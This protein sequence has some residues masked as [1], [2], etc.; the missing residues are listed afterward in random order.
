SALTDEDGEF[1]ILDIP[2]GRYSVAVTFIGYDMITKSNV[3]VLLDLTT[4]L[5]FSIKIRTAEI[6]EPII[7]TAERPLV[8][9]D[10]TASRYTL[11][12]DQIAYLPN[13][14][15]IADVLTNMS[16]AVIGRNGKL[17]IRG[18]RAGH[19]T[20]IFN[21]VNVTDP[22]NRNVGLRI[23]PSTLEEI[24]LTSG[25][26]PAEY[27]EAG[28]GVVNAV[29]REGG[30]SYTGS[31]KIYDGSTQKFDVNTGDFE[32]LARSDNQAVI[33]SISGP[34]EF[35]GQ[36]KA[37]FFVAA[38]GLRDGGY[39]PHNF[40]KSKTLTGKLTARP[41]ANIKI[42]V[43]G[44]IFR[45]A[46]DKFDH[47]DVNGISYNFNLDGSGLIKKE[48]DVLGLRSTLS[49]NPTTIIN[50]G[51]GHFRSQFKLAPEH[52]FDT[53]WNEWPGFVPDSD[54][55]Y[56]P[57]NGTL[58]VDNY[59]YAEEYGYTG[60]TY[61]DDFSPRYSFRRASYNTI[62]AN[63][64]KQF[65]KS[66]QLKV[67][68]EFRKYD[69]FWDEKQFLNPTPFG[70]KY[71]YFPSYGY[72]YAQHKLEYSDVII[73]AGLRYDYFSSR[74]NY[75]EQSY[76]DGSSFW[77]SSTPKSQ[78]SPR[79]GVSHP[80]AENTILR[81]NYGYFF[82]APS[83]ANMF[84]NLNGEINS[85]FPLL[86]NP[87]LKPEKTIA[88]EIGLGHAISPDLVLDITAYYKD[89]ENLVATR[90]EFVSPAFTV[91]RFFNEDYSSVKGFDISLTKRRSRYLSGVLNYSFMIAK[92]NSPEDRFAYYNIIT[93]PDETLPT[94]EYFL[95]FDQR[96]TIT[97]NLDL[98]TTRGWRGKPLGI[99]MKGAWGLNI[100]GRYG[101]G[102]PFTK[103]NLKTGSRVGG[104][105]EFRMP[106]TY[107]I[108][109]RVN[110]DIFFGQSKMF[111]S[112]FVEVENLFNRKNVINVYPT[113]GLPDD[114]GVAYTD[115]GAL[116]TSAEASRLYDLIVRDPQN[117]GRP[118]TIRTG[119]QFNF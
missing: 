102:L 1:Y 2:A 52:L 84:M 79:L 92:G 8:Q 53:Y 44:T 19:L 24:N 37:N 31:I 68:G 70:E 109:A 113:T 60:F 107:T 23:V 13:A 34:I 95:D 91:T 35:A 63:I 108:D 57:S 106:F 89:I 26:F 98:R 81:F 47:R 20:Y 93:N 40:K 77:S 36:G 115:G 55:N 94:K 51:I 99:P 76:I 29:T 110:R 17:H 117:Y 64:V 75:L 65:D 97:V 58:H 42:A 38:E 18:G 16:G 10:L 62:D 14:I 87:D 4:P 39:L 59:N 103:V 22:F 54:G 74:V 83:F 71:N 5:D 6:T 11:T 32:K 25:G 78:V 90:E 41:A 105:N 69:I 15:S 85:V 119:L 111:I 56:D 86:G 72:L 82:Q 12:A 50:A 33:V 67:G 9:K 49:L 101:S 73:N 114:D 96:H 66:N 61:G 88:Y 46:A 116:V 43:S 104:R 30:D 21:G 28:S 112:F 45:D 3:R 7:V 118:R 27:G 48:S 100:V 80:V